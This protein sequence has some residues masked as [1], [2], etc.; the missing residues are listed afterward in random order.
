MAG[1]PNGLLC[2]VIHMAVELWCGA[3]LGG[4][5]LGVFTMSDLLN[6]YGDLLVNDT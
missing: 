5:K 4:S 6:I 2:V 3:S 1:V